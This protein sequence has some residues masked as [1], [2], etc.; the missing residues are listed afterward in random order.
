MRRLRRW[1]PVYTVV[2]GALTLVYAE[3]SAAPAYAVLLVLFSVVAGY[4]NTRLL[5]DEGLE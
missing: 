2:A 1:L 4:F 5:V 3:R